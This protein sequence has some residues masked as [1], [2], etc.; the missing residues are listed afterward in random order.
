MLAGL[1]SS[2]DL[3]PAEAWQVASAFH[4]LGFEA[5]AVLIQHVVAIVICL[6]AFELFV[7]QYFAVVCNAYQRRLIG[8]SHVRQHN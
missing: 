3:E 5:V 4:W 2:F 7:S 6:V 1:V 8:D